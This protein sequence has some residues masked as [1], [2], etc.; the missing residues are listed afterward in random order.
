MGKKNMGMT[1]LRNA[2]FTGRNE[3][4]SVYNIVMYDGMGRMGYT[5]TI[6]LNLKIRLRS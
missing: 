4:I 1:M 5:G 3:A 2:G 6:K